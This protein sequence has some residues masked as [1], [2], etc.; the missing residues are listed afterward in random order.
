MTIPPP[1]FGTYG[2]PGPPSPP[3]YG[4]L[5][6]VP[7]PGHG[8]G[9]PLV[10]GVAEGFGGWF[11]RL[12][13]VLRRS[14]KSLLLISWVTFGVPIAAFVTVVGI[15]LGRLVVVSPPGSGQSPTFDTA[16]AGSFLLVVIVGALLL[17]YLTSASQAAAV[18]TVTRQAVGRPAPLGSA[19]VYGLRHGLRL[20]GW[21]IAYGLIVGVGF[22]ACILPGLYFALAGC[23]YVPVALYRRGMSPIGTS[24]SLI[25]KSFWGSLG[26]MALLL[27]MVYGVQIVLGVPVQLVSAQ[28]HALGVALSVVLQVLTAPLVLVL[29]VGAVLLFAELW[30]KRAPTSAGELDAALG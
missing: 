30:N 22:V 17:G 29:N 1:D 28:S 20:F 6:P 7:P 3:Q 23:L 13:G 9:D 18:W 21:S 27:V 8:Q 5:V 25:N 12:F 4:Y 26:R 2:Q 16:A 14:W 11:N 19:L 15:A 24:F 10:T